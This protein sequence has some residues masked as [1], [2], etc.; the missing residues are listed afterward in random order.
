MYRISAAVSLFVL[1]L[2]YWTHSH[3]AVTTSR[4]PITYWNTNTLIQACPNIQ[5]NRICDPD[6]ILTTNTNTNTNTQPST[7]QITSA[8]HELESNHPLTCHTNNNT[9]THAP[10]FF[11]PTN[12]NNNCSSQQQSTK[13]NTN[14]IQT[15]SGRKI[16][17][18]ITSHIKRKNEK[19][20]FKKKNNKAKL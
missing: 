5:N 20:K 19:E 18:T 6:H 13:G 14:D 11:Q 16:L 9:Q 8:I 3:A 4:N 7:L 17:G 2:T 10:V 15:R 12:S 1:F